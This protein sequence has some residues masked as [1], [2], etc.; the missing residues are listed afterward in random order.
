MELVSATSRVYKC[1]LNEV[2]TITFAAHNVD[3]RVTYLFDDEGAGHN[4]QGNS[5]SFTMTRHFTL[6]RIFFHF[7][8]ESGTGGSYDVRLS[9]SA[10][11]SFPDPPPVLQAG[12]FVPFRSYTFVA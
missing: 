2:V 10:G 11:G 12:D 9:G 7:V 3:L 1:Q 6:L 5:L 4:V 8:N